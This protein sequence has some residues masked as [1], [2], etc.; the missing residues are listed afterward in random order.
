MIKVYWL[1]ENETDNIFKDGYVGI[2][3]N[4][5]IRFYQHRARFGNFK[6]K[7]VFYGSLEQRRNMS[8][9]KWSKK[10]LDYS[11]IIMLSKQSL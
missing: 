7:I 8:E 9:A 6:S 2:T 10:N 11:N 1:Y 4:H 5:K 3:K